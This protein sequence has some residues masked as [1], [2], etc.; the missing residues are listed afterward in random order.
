MELE[1]EKRVCRYLDQVIRDVRS[2]E[3]TQEI[4]LG[5]GLPDV[6]RVI[7]AWGQ[8]ILRGKEWRGD[9]VIL[10]GGIMTWMLYAPEDG[11]NP[12]CLDAWI[13][14]K[15]KWDLPEDAREGEIRANCLLRSLDG[16]S[17]S[18][19]K[20]LARAVISV[21][22]R[23]LCP[24]EAELFQPG[25]VPQAVQMLKQTYPIR[26]LR[27][28]GEKAFELDEELTLKSTDPV[29][30]KLYG[31]RLHP[32]ITESRVKGENLVFRGSGKLYLLGR[33]ADGMLHTWEF[34]LPFSQIAQLQREYGQDAEGELSVAVTGLEPELEAEGKLRVKC[35]MVGQYLVDDRELVELVE[36]AYSNSR[37]LEVHTRELE[38]PAILD[39]RSENI[40]G[41]QKLPVD[42][43]QVVDGVFLPEQP[44]IRQS[45]NG[46]DLEIPGTF[47][48]LY[49][50]ENGELK[51]ASLRMEL[52]E[53]VE[54]AP[55]V[56]LD[57]EIQQPDSPGI[58]VADGSLELSVELP[59]KITGSSRQRW[60]QVS[61]MT[62]GAEQEA[63]PARP[64]LILCRRGSE[65][66]WQL[67]KENGSS[68][69]AIRQINALEDEAESDRF[70]L[71][72]VS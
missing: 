50:G 58:T 39:S 66:L 12:R 18:P 56:R 15:L 38:L 45:E 46:V 36:D 10:S 41:E 20:L 34:D 33:T 16:R 44:R 26:L 13:P 62:L 37:E 72:P 51:S 14:F 68:V 28:A 49:Y 29:P 11:T 52:E 17:I 25:E 30:V 61:G 57:G 3:L 4:R 27:E 47:Q 71:I 2:E 64:S 65:S 54:T 60:S 63:D 9:C 24:S 19:R 69:E 5:D 59:L 6:G 1:F 53:S 48:V 22:I 21:Q 67:A 7:G 40:Y 35:G 42:A 55:N 8:V 32:R 70:L 43:S 23:V 31:C